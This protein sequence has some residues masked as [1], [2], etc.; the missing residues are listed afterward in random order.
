LIVDLAVGCAPQALG[1]GARERRAVSESAVDGAAAGVDGSAVGRGQR[2]HSGKPGDPGRTG[3]DNRRFLGAVA[4][5]AKTGIRWCDLPERFDKA[6][7]VWRRFDRW[8]KKGVWPVLF[9]RLG[10]PPPQCHRAFLRN[11]ALAPQGRH[12]L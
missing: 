8:G 3:A 7:S 1:G 6:N 10:F 2:P 12:P 11:D 4:D 9:A 5:V